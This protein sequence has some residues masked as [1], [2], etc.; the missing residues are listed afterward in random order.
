MFIKRVSINKLKNM[1]V[2]EVIK[3]KRI[4]KENLKLKIFR[5]IREH[6]IHCHNEIQTFLQ[7]KYLNLLNG[8]VVQLKDQ[9]WVYVDW[10]GIGDGE[11]FPIKKRLSVSEMKNLMRHAVD[12]EAEDKIWEHTCQSM[13]GENW[14]R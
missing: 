9:Y 1:T 5:D 14:E 4:K 3:I 2:D 11:I 7:L 12:T 6:I 13:I 10:T 8:Q